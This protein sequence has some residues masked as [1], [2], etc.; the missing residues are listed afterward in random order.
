MK[1]IKFKLKYKDIS[2]KETITSLQK[3]YSQDFRKIFTNLDLI[4]DESFINSLNLQNKKLLEYTI[5]EAIAFND[6]DIANKNN[7]KDNIESLIEKGTLSKKQFKHLIYLQKRLRSKVVFGGRANLVKLSQNKGNK[8]EWKRKRL[9]PITFYGE[10]STYGNRFFDLKDIANGKIL[11][12][13]NKDTRINL[14]FNPKKQKKD[15]QILGDLVK[16]KLI[17]VTV[18]ISDEFLY[19]TFN[20]SI[21][22]K[23]NLNIKAFYKEIRHI[24]D[25]KDRKNRIKIRYKEHENYL[26]NKNNSLNSRYMGLDLNPDGIGY[27]ILDKTNNGFKIIVKGYF[28]LS[29]VIDSNKRKYETTIVVKELF[30]LIKHNRV[31]Y[32]VLEDLNISPKDYGNKVS[33]RK[34]NNLWNRNLIKQLIEKRTNETGVILRYI[35]PVYTSFIGNI[36]HNIYDPIAASIEVCRRGLYQYIKGSNSFYPEFNVTDFVNDEMYDKIKECHT[37][38]D[39]Y[40]LYTTSKRSYRRKL[41]ENNFLANS[42]GNTKS[43]VLHLTFL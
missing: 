26:I 1:T 17:P 31:S 27:S 8:A 16:K 18:K 36:Q 42:V 23:T 25:K 41:F 32:I 33:N 10:K 9:L 13:Y 29:K 3:K 38:K 22:N 40:K 43:L 37:W 19:L 2:D 28:D 24:K 12:K 14:T 15:L 7:I 35:N 5:K 39:L 30:K 6:R 11:F 34:I 4:V 20:E 21:V